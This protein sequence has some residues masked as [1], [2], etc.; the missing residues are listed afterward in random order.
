MRQTFLCSKTTQIFMSAEAQ[1]SR[2]NTIP[3]MSSFKKK[4]PLL[5]HSTFLKIVEFSAVV[6]HG[7][8][9][10]KQMSSRVANKHNMKMQ[11]LG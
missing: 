10:I 8:K 3:V 1:F 11:L 6:T 4:T 7:F 9:E 2:E 5:F